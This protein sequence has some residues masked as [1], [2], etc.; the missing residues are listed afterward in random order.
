[1]SLAKV[2][3]NL[4]IE[5]HKSLRKVEDERI[6]HAHGSA[7]SILLKWDCLW[8]Q[9]I[10][11]VQF[12]SKYNYISHRSRKMTLTFPNSLL[13][14][15]QRANPKPSPHNNHHRTLPLPHNTTITTQH[16]A[17][18][19]RT[20]WRQAYS[21]LKTQYTKADV[22]AGWWSGAPRSKVTQTHPPYSR[23]CV[24]HIPVTKGSVCQ[25][26]CNWDSNSSETMLK[27]DWVKLEN[28]LQQR[29]QL[30]KWRDKAA[31]TKSLCQLYIQQQQYL[32]H[33]EY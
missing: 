1:M 23:Q 17:S 21:V 11:S 9:Y 8:T 14:G 30:T 31:V 19:Y 25:D 22:S 5:D 4:Y 28:F 13:W 12:P 7:G 16:K 3:K 32:E 15:E 33:T 26:R 20:V 2:V 6:A 18:T 29:E 27:W 10:N 24:T